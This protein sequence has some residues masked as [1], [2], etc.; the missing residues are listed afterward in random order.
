M[1]Q[2]SQERILLEKE[3]LGLKPWELSPCETHAGECPYP[4]GTAGHA[5]WERARG[6]Q[7]Q[8]DDILAGD[9]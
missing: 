2:P 4:S 9:A 7:K 3:I 8:I 1:K 6:L 5:S